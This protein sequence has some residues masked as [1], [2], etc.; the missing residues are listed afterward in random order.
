MIIELVLLL[1]LSLDVAGVADTC[2]AELLSLGV[3][4]LLIYAV[5]R[6][7]YAV[8][9]TGNGL[10]VTYAEDFA[11]VLGNTSERDNAVLIVVESYPLEAVPVIVVL[12]HSRCVAVEL[13]GSLEEVV[14][15]TVLVVAQQVPLE[16]F[17]GVPFVKLADFA[18]HKHQ[19]FAGVS[20][21]V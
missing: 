2:T 14:E 16:L 8:V 17:V 12:V 7:T 13:I 19:L 20:H 4:Y 3:E 21:H 9:L 1:V 11:A 5:N 10:E 6:N 15:L 18:A